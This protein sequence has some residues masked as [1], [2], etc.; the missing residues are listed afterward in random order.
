MRGRL[1]RRRAEKNDLQK[2]RSGVKNILI[3]VEISPAVE[4]N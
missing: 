1:A 4:E 3:D 2:C